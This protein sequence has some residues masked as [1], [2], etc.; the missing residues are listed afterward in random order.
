M[1]PMAGLTATPEVLPGIP[2]ARGLQEVAGAGFL[3]YVSAAIALLS[4]KLWFRL[5]SSGASTGD[6]T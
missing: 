4:I 2:F 5:H 6:R 3:L 1:L